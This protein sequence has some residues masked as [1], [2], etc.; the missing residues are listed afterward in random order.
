MIRRFGLIG[1]P[2][3]HYFSPDY[4]ARKFKQD[5][6]SD[7]VYDTF[8]IQSIN[9]LNHVLQKHQDIQGLNVTIPYKEAVIPYLNELSE[10]AKLIGAVNT[11]Q[12]I[13]EAKG[14]KKIGHNTD[15]QGFR[16]SLSD[17][18]GSARPAAL[19]LGSGG[20]SKA[21]C[22][23]LREMGIAFHIVSRSGSEKTISY[24]SL[25]AKTIQKHSL[26]INTTPLGM[27]PK[28]DTKPLIPYKGLSS[29]HF[30]FDLVYHPEITAFMK[31]GNFA[32]AKTKN[33]FD[34]LMLQAEASW[35]IW[36][37]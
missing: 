21:V 2:L 17:L 16:D 29:N 18:I 36:N 6:I 5:K 28:V 30:L 13:K 37:Q 22:Y 35:R 32:G 11:I 19:V 25:T 9:E 27:H 1:Y 15:V 7:C 4:F 23:V 34:M 10:E 12:F 14:L 8:E 33:G 20:S 31:E 24:G 26:I 3:G